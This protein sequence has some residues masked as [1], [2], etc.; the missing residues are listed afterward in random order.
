MKKILPF[1]FAA[2]MLLGAFGHIAN[3]DFYAPLIPDF[4][5]ESLANIL[6]TIAEGAIGIALLLPAYRKWG[7]LGFFL[8]M[9]AFL[10][11]HIWDLFKET[12]ITGSQTGAIIRLAIQFLLIYGGWWLYKRS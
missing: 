1:V 3:P 12:S 8:L 4:I 10:P 2:L 11:L 7:A 9:L 5:P 6:S